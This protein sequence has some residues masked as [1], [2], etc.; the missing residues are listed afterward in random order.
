MR[1]DPHYGPDYLSVLGQALLHQERY[2][3]AA[4]FIERAVNRQPDND[5]HY[6][7]LAVA[8]GHLG[9]IRRRPCRGRE[10]Q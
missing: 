1:L 9:R 7:T 10:V 6:V 5:Q 8:Y 3:E 2:E 4:G